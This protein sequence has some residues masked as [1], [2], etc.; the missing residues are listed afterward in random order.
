[1]ARS[2]KKSPV[3]KDHTTGM[4]TIANRKVR[5]RLS[6]VVYMLANGNAYRKIFCSYSI[7]DWSFRETYADYKLKAEG[8]RNDYENGIGRFNSRKDFSVDMTYWDWFKTY[9]RK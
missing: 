1:M 4:K 5:R 3:V 6:S 7:S 8:Y 9:K 2:Y